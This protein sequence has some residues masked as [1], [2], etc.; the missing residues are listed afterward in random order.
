MDLSNITVVIT[1]FRSNHK[2]FSCIDS[3]PKEVKIIIVENSDDFKFKESVENYRANVDC[4][5]LKLNLGY[6]Y[7]NNFGLL[8]VKTKYALVINPDVRLKKDTLNYFFNTILRYPDFWIIGPSFNNNF[9]VVT[10]VETIKGYSI[11]FN[12]K[13]FNNNFFDENFFLYF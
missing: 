9:Q 10:K 8:K 12:L 2:I 6:S 13:K 4:F 7:G 1:T 11:F 5:L 3:I